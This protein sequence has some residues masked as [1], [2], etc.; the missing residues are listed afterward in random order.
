MMPAD[1]LTD[2]R[3]LALSDNHRA[4]FGTACKALIASGRSIADV[5]EVIKGTKWRYLVTRSGRAIEVEHKDD[6]YAKYWEA[7]AE[8]KSH[9]DHIG[10]EKYE[11]WILDAIRACKRA[12]DRANLFITDDD[13]MGNLDREILKF[14]EGTGYRYT[15]RG[16][17]E[18][19][20]EEA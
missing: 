7:V 6:L 18:C 5:A 17:E 2:L 12:Y 14:F 4:D 19:E 9:R 10:W 8:M 20:D 15:Y 3:D 16:I 11:D 1:S 13:N